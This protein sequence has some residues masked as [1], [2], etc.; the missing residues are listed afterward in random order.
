ME[1]EALGGLRGAVLVAAAATFL[2]IEALLLAAAWRTYADG[3]PAAD[4]AHPPVR[5]SRA[6]ELLWTVLPAVGLLALLVLGA[7]A[8]WGN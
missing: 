4:A 7:R 2:V 3:R 5:L 1:G 8:L 6:W